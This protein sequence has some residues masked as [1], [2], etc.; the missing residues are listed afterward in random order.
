MLPKVDWA[1]WQEIT[2]QPAALMEYPTIKQLP[3]LEEV[4]ADVHTLSVPKFEHQHVPKLR[5]ECDDS[6]V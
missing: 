1:K 2:T 4:Y 5:V 6:Q 3:P